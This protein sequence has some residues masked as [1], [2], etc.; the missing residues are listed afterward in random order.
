MTPYIM[1]ERTL[2]GRN[3]VVGIDRILFPPSY[4]S[5]PQPLRNV[6]NTVVRIPVI[7]AGLI[8]GENAELMGLQALQVGNALLMAGIQGLGGYLLHRRTP[9][10]T[11]SCFRCSGYSLRDY[12]IGFIA[13]GRTVKQW[14]VYNN[15]PA[16]NDTGRRPSVGYFWNKIGEAYLQTRLGVETMY[17]A[18]L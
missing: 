14:F 4:S 16:F 2:S 18:H 12:A 7:I 8:V 6:V 3:D 11:P 13:F 5:L 9:H 17:G 10:P 15:I 1:S